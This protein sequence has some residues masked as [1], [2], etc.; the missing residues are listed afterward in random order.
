VNSLTLFLLGK[1]GK[2]LGVMFFF[3]LPFRML[4]KIIISTQQLLNIVT[5]YKFLLFLTCGFP[6]AKDAPRRKIGNKKK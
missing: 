2:L 4:N 5:K 3:L 1:F 6:A